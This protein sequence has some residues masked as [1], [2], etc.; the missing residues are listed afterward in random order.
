MKNIIIIVFS[1]FSFFNSAFSQNSCQ[2]IVTLNTGYN[3]AANTTYSTGVFDNYWSVVS[4]PTST[5]CGT[6]TFP[7]PS[8]VISP[9]TGWGITPYSN[10]K[11]L[12]FRPTS[13]LSC[14]N[15]CATGAVPLVF[16]RKFC[17]RAADTIIINT[18]LRTDNAACLFVD[19]VA[20]PLKTVV[21][22]SGVLTTYTTVI[23]SGGCNEC[24]RWDDTKSFNGNYDAR[25]TNF[26]I[27]LLAGT[28][29]IQ[30]R[31]RN[32]SGD[33]FGVMLEGTIGSKINK[34]NFECPDICTPN[35]GTIAIKKILDKD[36]DG[37]YDS[38][39]DGLGASW[40]F[41]VTGPGGFNTTVTTDATGYAFVTGLAVGNYVV[42]E[43]TQAGYTATTPSQTTILS[44]T[45]SQILT[46]YNCPI[47]CSEYSN[48]VIKCGAIVGGIQTY[49]I[50][51]T[52]TNNS[53]VPSS[54]YS[55]TPTSASAGVVSGL[56]VTPA[57]IPGFGTALVKF[58]YKL[59]SIS[60][61]F[62][63]TI[64]F[65]SGNQCVKEQCIQLPQC[66]NFKPCIDTKLIGITC[67]SVVNGVQTYTVSGIVSNGSTVSTALNVS[68]SISGGTVSITSPNT[69]AANA[70]NIP[71]SFTYTPANSSTNPCFVVFLSSTVT[72]T[73][74][75]TIC[76]DL[77]KKCCMDVTYKLECNKNV[78]TTHP[79]T[80]VYTVT[81][82]NPTNT[83]VTIPMASTTGTISPSVITAP[84]NTSTVFNVYYNQTSTAIPLKACIKFGVGIIPLTVP[85]CNQPVDC[86]P[87]PIC[88]PKPN[89][90]CPT[91]SIKPCCIT[92]NEIKYEFVA[93]LVPTTICGM[94][95][96]V[97]PSVGVQG[98]NAYYP[99]TFTPIV[100]NG[101][102]SFSPAVQ[103]NTNLTYY[104]TVPT[105]TSSIVSIK[106]VTCGG[107]TCDVEKFQMGTSVKKAVVSL[108]SV[109]ITD[110]LF[111][112]KFRLDLS[113]LSDVAKI[114]S[115]SFI[116]VDGD[117]FEDLF[118]AINSREIDGF[119][120]KTMIPLSDA[121]QGLSSATFIF[122]NPINASNYNNGEINIVTKRRVKQF[123]VVMFD[124]LGLQ[125][126]GSTISGLA[127]PIS[128][129]A[130]KDIKNNVTSLSIVPNPAS[131]E[132]NMSY[133]L[134]SDQTMQIDLLDI[135]GKVVRAID[136][137]FKN[138]N[139]LQNVEFNVSDIKSGFYMVRFVNE[140]GQTIVEKLNII[141]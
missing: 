70:T 92:T 127:L 106:Y 101:Y 82:V 17:V 96:T 23:A 137:G 59:G 66:N 124:E 138:A 3:H 32:N 141:H 4:G 78:N 118:F 14:N 60:P 47:K 11:W 113:K 7:S 16:E 25:A 29:N 85:I 88:M 71:F 39:I 136:K 83:V 72:Q 48:L 15:T 81:V 134:G 91:T 33:S 69:I 41:N 117:S 2:N 112:M 102:T 13:S 129:T 100:I 40:Q 46:F 90:C 52:V 9:A 111:A 18:N 98:G 22:S 122:K 140:N 95:M 93:P 57:I 135:S 139:Q 61:C 6:Y 108:K 36:C 67:G 123:K 74:K 125:I 80:Y 76:G 34:S 31:A 105:G 115:V 119:E 99:S 128:T 65:A 75:D 133:F 89:K 21:A 56:T 107:D 44:A 87:L 19:G 94:I 24:D 42:T 79:E 43:V 37:K 130:A 38:T 28:H 110:T 53:P 126:S 73:C 104:I 58:N 131:D 55:I 62:V 20:I 68:S 5:L 86:V 132:V 63:S 121:L 1:F 120:N 84:A 49:D 12:S 103:A 27:Y 30:I 35:N 50:Q 8:A 64:N 54:T 109:K 77:P 51:A 10:S 97:V 116:P 26:K 45:T 114:K